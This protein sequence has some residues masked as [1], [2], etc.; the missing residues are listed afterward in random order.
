MAIQPVT[1]G[2]YLDRNGHTAIAIRVKEG[3]VAFLTMRTGTIDVEQVGVER[4]QH[5]F[6]KHLP[7]YPLLR[8]VKKYREPGVLVSE[9]A[10]KLI[11]AIISNAERDVAALHNQA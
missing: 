7:N 6:P 4:F 10:D 5:D 3:K 11:V 1:T 8:A 9:K 2:V